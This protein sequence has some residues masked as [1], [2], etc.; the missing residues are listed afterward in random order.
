M[1]TD[2]REGIVWF[3][4]LE[5]NTF[6]LRWSSSTSFSK[7][8]FS[9]SLGGTTLHR[10]S[11]KRVIIFSN[12]VKQVTVKKLFSLKKLLK[13]HKNTCLFR[14]VFF[15]LFFLHYFSSSVW[16]S[17]SLTH[18]FQFFSSLIPSTQQRLVHNIQLPPPNTT[19]TVL[20]LKCLFNRYFSL[21]ITK[22]QVM[23]F[24]RENLAE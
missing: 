3:I 13:H 17:H 8:P 6:F 14:F 1:Y 16:S 15:L 11:Q 19:T 5:G 2:R 18:S 12:I 4:C 21:E 22:P 7:G 20:P 24:S 9:Y 10:D 23:V